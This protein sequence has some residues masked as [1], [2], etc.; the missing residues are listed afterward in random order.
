MDFSFSDE[1]EALRAA[2][3]AYLADRYPLERIAAMS[4]GEGFDRGAWAEIAEMGWTGI[5]VPAS[6]GG[7]GLGFLEEAVVAEELGRGLYPGPFL[8][9]VVMGL[10]AARTDAGVSASIARGTHVATVAWA[11]SD[12]RFASEPPPPVRWNRAD[13]RLSGSRAFVPDV[14]VADLF[15][16]IGSD[17]G[18][19]CVWQVDREAPGVRWREQATID[20][21]R[22]MGEVVLEEAPARELSRGDDA[23]RSVR[24]RGLAALAAE[25]VGVGSAALSLAVDHART[26]EQFGRPIGSF[27]AVAHPLAQAYLEVETA[28]SLA[29]WAA[30]AVSQRAPEASRAAA[31]AKARAS[32]AA[33]A[34]CERAIQSHGGVGFTWDHPLHRYYKRALGIA[35]FLET[36]TEL[37]ARLASELLG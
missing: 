18:V 33:V 31:A 19:P 25:A 17:G 15:L 16:V 9:S 10:E 14:S 11:G 35:S 32:E 5:S 29:Y 21:T 13:G 2:V 1:Q 7:A 8:S 4:D 22:R 37:R 30:W 24:D 27:Q 12:G 6:Q 23:C 3:R 20:G 34:A 26:R 28:R 36:G